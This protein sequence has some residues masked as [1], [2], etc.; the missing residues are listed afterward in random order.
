MLTPPPRRAFVVG[1]LVPDDLGGDG[2]AAADELGSSAAEHVRA[3]GGEV[4]VVA[5]G[6]VGG[7][8]VAGGDGDGDAESGGGLAGGVE[9]VHGLRGPT[10]LGAAPADGDDAGVVG[11]V[12]DRGGDGVDEALV[13]VGREVDDDLGAGRD[14]GRHFDV[15]HDFAVGAVG[16]AGGVLAAVYRDRR[17]EGAFWPRVLK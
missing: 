8:V 7:T 11:G 3:G 6:A 12:V 10:G 13:G 5:V 4:D 1:Q 9:G 2:G 16:V 15:E 17:D 14:G